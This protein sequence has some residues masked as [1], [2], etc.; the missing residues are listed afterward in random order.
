MKKVPLLQETS[1]SLTKVSAGK[2]CGCA[3]PLPPAS[4]TFEPP[5]Y[6]AKLSL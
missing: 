4:T 6:V 2:D 5:Y 3:C 1:Q